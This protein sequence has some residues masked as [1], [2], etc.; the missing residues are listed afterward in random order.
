[1]PNIST[2]YVANSVSIFDVSLQNTLFQK[3]RLIIFIGKL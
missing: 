1:M 2:V 3:T